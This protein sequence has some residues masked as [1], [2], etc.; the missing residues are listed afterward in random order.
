MLLAV[1]EMTELLGGAPS[2]IDGMH[3]WVMYTQN[4]YWMIQMIHKAARQ[5]DSTCIKPDAHAEQSFGRHLMSV[6]L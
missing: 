2:S 1:T 5:E 6:P 4:T 3:L